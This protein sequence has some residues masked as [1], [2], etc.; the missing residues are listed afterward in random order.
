MGGII[1]EDVLVGNKITYYLTGM[2]NIE[3]GKGWA[4][5]TRAKQQNVAT[6]G[7]HPNGSCWESVE[8][9][10]GLNPLKQWFSIGLIPLP[11]HL[12]PLSKPGTTDVWWIWGCHS[13][14][15]RRGCYQH[16]M[17]KDQKYWQASWDTKLSL[18][19]RTNPTTEAS[20]NPGC[21]SESPGKL[22]NLPI[23]TVC[24]PGDSDFT[25]PGWG[26]KH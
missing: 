22:D 4:V 26:I 17:S 1:G 9:N 19:L 18:M 7:R 15:G 13:W 24:I 10:G 12:I 3:Q 25:G 23:T 5:L 8:E 14:R 20:F 11:A 2:E 6:T 21:S 16:V